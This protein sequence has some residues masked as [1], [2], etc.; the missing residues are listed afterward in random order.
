MLPPSPCDSREEA[1]PILDGVARFEVLIAALQTQISRQLT[2][3]AVLQ[4]LD[5][6]LE[7]QLGL[8]SGNSGKPPSSDGL[9]K[10]PARTSS[11]RGRSGKKA[12]MFGRSLRCSAPLCPSALRVATP[13]QQ[14]RMLPHL[15]SDW[16]NPA[17]TRSYRRDPP[18]YPT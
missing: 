2:L 12:C 8:N 15:A 9:K 13:S 4:A 7:R 1:G 5:A 14:R 16:H 11:L 18:R 3:I 10:K 6:E 17:F